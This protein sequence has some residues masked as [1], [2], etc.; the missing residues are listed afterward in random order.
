MAPCVLAVL[1][2]VIPVT[3]SDE[4]PKPPSIR[5]DTFGEITVNGALLTSDIVIDKGEVR[6]RKKGPSRKDRATYG[7][8]PLTPL[9]EIPWDC[10]IL[11][12]GTGIHGRLPVVDAFKEEARRRGVELIILKTKEAVEYF[13]KNFGPDLNAVL[14][15]TC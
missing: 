1:L 8:T 11:V 6:R 10:K 5:Y 13:N 7:H 15:I 4:A 3:E 2:M 14:H 9:E 12:V